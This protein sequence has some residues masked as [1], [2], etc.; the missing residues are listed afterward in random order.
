M[1]DQTESAHCIKVMRGQIG[2]RVV[3]IDG[4]GGY[5]DAE[6]ITENPKNCQLQII[7]KQLNYEPLPYALSIA[8]APTKSIDR[9]EWFIEK[10]AEIGI[11]NIIPIYTQRS[12]RKN[13]RLDRIE[14]LLISAVKQ[15]G[16]AYLPKIHEPI[17]YISFL[18][19]EFGG[20][21]FIAHCME[22][23]RSDL[24]KMELSDEITFLIGPEGDFTP[25]EVQQATQKGYIPVTLGKYRLRT[26]TAGVVAC[27][28]VNFLK[29]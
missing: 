4:D 29:G 24:R 9:F 20:S 3:L 15:S 10:V 8:I 23:E 6:I 19:K 27:S 11:S 17:P 25:E 13:L 5:Y 1:L 12:E 28:Y 14:K 22:D 7:S 18:E 2:D 16:K 26:E 21:K